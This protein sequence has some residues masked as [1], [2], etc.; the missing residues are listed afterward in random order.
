MELPGPSLPKQCT[1]I[2]KGKQRPKK[3][4]HVSKRLPFAVAS[5]LDRRESVLTRAWFPTPPTALSRLR[6]EA[7]P[8]PIMPSVSPGGL[9]SFPRLSNL[10]DRLAPPKV[11]GT[12]LMRANP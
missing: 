12:E 3:V 1:K 10:A 8:L 2:V 4:I 6:I 7:V 11:L 5:A 9:V